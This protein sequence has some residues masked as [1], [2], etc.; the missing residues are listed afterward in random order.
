MTV[1]P[2]RLLLDSNVWI[3]LFASNRQRCDTA[4]EL[5]D[6]AAEQGATLLYAASSAKDVY[7]ILEEREKRLLRAEGVEIT[8]AVAGAINEYAW[9]CLGA[10]GE[11]ATVVPVD[12]SDFWIAMKY[13]SI[14]ADFEDDLVL[15]AAER[16]KADYLVTSDEAL[17][18]R[19]PVAALPP[20]DVL[21]LVKA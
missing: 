15:A 2:T 9:G 17:L 14:H 5:V 11:I 6:W 21:A 19:S 3:D 10:M 8:S 12:Q 16:S 1:L 13:K 20:R 7:Y 4:R 18:R